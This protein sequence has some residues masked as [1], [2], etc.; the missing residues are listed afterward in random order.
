M[1]HTNHSRSLFAWTLIALVVLPLTFGACGKS[2]GETIDD[3]T[4][5]ARVKTALLN[6]PQV[7]GTEDRCRH[8]DGRGDDVGDRQIAGG[9]RSRH[10]AR[11]AGVGRQG[12]EVD[13]PGQPGK[14]VHSSTRMRVRGMPRSVRIFGI[15]STSAGG[16]HTKHSVAGS[17]TSS[18]SASRLRRPRGPVQSASDAR[19]TVCRNSM[20]PASARR[21]ELLFVRELVRRARAVEQPDVAMGQRQRMAHHRSQRRDPG[22]AGDEHEAALVRRGRK[23]ERAERTFDV[24]ELTAI[25][26]QVRAGC[27]VGFDADQSSRRP[28]STRILRC[29]GDRVRPPLLVTMAGDRHRL[30]CGVVE[31]LAVQIEPRDPR[32]RRRQEHLANR[33]REQQGGIC[34]LTMALRRARGFLLRLV[35]RR[36][37]AIMTG[38]ALAVPAGWVEFSGRVWRLVGRRAGV[39]R[40]RH[41]DCDLLDGADGTEPGLDRRRIG[42]C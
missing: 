1:K 42:W 22:P 12:C 7:G 26:R 11:E 25:E 4:I 15:S 13:A 9:G 16:P 35:R 6:D 28:F 5:T 36:T 37:L 41:G 33:E 3:A 2:V 39:D 20:A 24:D 8:H 17:W 40:R 34:Y 18:S 10:S 30:T 23:R 27:S 29:R 38:L 19:V 14:L 31:R 21:A 32:A